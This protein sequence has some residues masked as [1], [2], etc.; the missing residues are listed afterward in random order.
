MTETMTPHEAARLLTDAAGFERALERRTEGLTMMVWGL[1]SS[2][3][4]ATYGLAAVLGATESA[5]VG[6]IFGTLWIP[7]VGAGLLVTFALWRS[8]ALSRPRAMVDEDT[9]AY[10]VRSIGLTLAITLFFSIFHPG[11]PTFPLAVLGAAWAL[12]AAF[13]L[14]R[15]HP[16]ERRFAFAAGA[17]LFAT[18]IALWITRAPI[19]VAGT[20]SM[21]APLV[22]LLGL[23]FWQTLR[24]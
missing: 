17:I 14:F 7:W 9:K 5:Y 21:A 11:G 18:G 19:E 13:N 6:W 15:S 12:V 1:V 22:V 10:W 8:A 24:G 23:G 3:M 4:F 2:A 20:V 16:E